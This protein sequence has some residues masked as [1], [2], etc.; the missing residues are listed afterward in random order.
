VT[1]HRTWCGYKE[2]QPLHGAGSWAR[3]SDV[4]L[5]V[6]CP[7]NATNERDASDQPLRTFM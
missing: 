3:V 4:V 2:A 6:V 5:L 1:E 7:G